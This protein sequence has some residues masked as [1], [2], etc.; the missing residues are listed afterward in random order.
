MVSTGQDEAA[1]TGQDEAAATGQDEAA[2]TGQ[3]E[4]AATG[5]DE[6]AATGQDEAAATGQDEAA[7]VDEVVAILSLVCSLCHYQEPQLLEKVRN[8]SA[9]LAVDWFMQVARVMKMVA[10]CASQWKEE[11]SQLYL[12]SDRHSTLLLVTAV[13]SHRCVQESVDIVQLSRS[14]AITSHFICESCNLYQ[15]VA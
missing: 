10:L 6:A 1:A 14:C 9:L 12:R 5:Q 13:L 2:A 4:A 15:S 11:S 8:S 3:D 7:A